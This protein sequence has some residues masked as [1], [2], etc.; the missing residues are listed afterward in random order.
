MIHLNIITLTWAT[1]NIKVCVYI[2]KKSAYPWVRTI[3]HT[4]LIPVH[5]PGHCLKTDSLLFPMRGDRSEVRRPPNIFVVSL[6]TALA[7]GSE[8]ERVNYKPPIAN[9]NAAIYM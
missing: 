2:D 8:A 1:C 5:C 3:V 9:N 4:I 6:Q 7:A